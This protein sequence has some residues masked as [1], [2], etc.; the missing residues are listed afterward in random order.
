MAGM[1]GQEEGAKPIEINVDMLDF[2]FVEECNDVATLKGICEQLKNNEYGYYPDLEAKALE[3]LFSLLPAAEVMK[4]KRLQYKTTPQEVADAEAS[5]SSWSENMSRRDA[6]IRGAQDEAAA[7]PTDSSDIF[8]AA[9]LKTLPKKR[10]LPPVRGSQLDSAS[11]TRTV[12]SKA[13][14][15]G[16]AEEK[17]QQERLSGYD[18]QAWDKFDAEEAGRA[19]DD[20]KDLLASL[21][22]GKS[23][24]QLKL[25]QVGLAL[26]A[27]CPV[28]RVP[29]VPCALCAVCPALTLPFLLTPCSSR[30]AR[31]RTRR[32][33][34][35]CRHNWALRACHPCSGRLARAGRRPRATSASASVRTRR[36]WTA[37]PGPWRWT[38][39][40]PSLTP[41]EPWPRCD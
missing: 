28:C 37:T 18:F 25:A 17:Q 31:R 20:E 34:S 40:T 24:E 10:A 19:V 21:Q 11:A 41:I 4:M 5:L 6:A 35:C 9:P 38:P 23:L 2:G 26:R 15:P 32:R 3:K 1:M 30:S 13:S 12:T 14:S 27:V 16:Q 33:C 36:R 29:C 8:S 39:S 22:P 7:G